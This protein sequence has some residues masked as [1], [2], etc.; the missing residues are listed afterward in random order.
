MSMFRGVMV[1][2]LVAESHHLKEL[3]ALDISDNGFS[4]PV[5]VQGKFA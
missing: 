1:C 3:K 5:E 4:D 2:C